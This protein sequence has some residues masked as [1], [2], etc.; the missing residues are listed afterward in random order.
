MTITR[1][2]SAFSSSAGERDGSSGEQPLDDLHGLGE[3]VDTHL[4]VVER[5]PRLVVLRL[6]VAGTEA[7]LEST[8]RQ[9][10]GG[11]GLAGDDHRMPEVVVQHGGSH[12]KPRRRFRGG[13]AAATGAK[14]SAR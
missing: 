11:R 13:D 8:V 9:D 5:Q 12:A 10:V 6:H 14:N 4:S 7:E 2:T 1:C 3:T